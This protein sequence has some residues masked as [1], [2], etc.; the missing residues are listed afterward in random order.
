MRKEFLLL[1]KIIKEKTKN[2]KIYYLHNSGNYGDSLIRYGT[3][4]FFQDINLNFKQ[5][6]TF[7]LLRT[8][9]W[10]TLIKPNATLIFAGSGAWCKF[11][12]REAFI[13][14][15]SKRFKNIIILPSTFE[16]TPN[17]PNAIFF[18]R[19]NYESKENV[20]S[21]IFCHDMAFYIGSIES[22]KGNG[23]GY[24]FRKDIESLNK[25]NFIPQNIDISL[26]GNHL[27]PIFDF[28]NEISKY[29]IIY[30]D[31]LHV[32][33]GASL[34]KKE[35]HLFPNSYFKNKAIYLSSLKPFYENVYFHENF[36]L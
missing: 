28:I 30:T 23:K 15:I 18:R 25:V 21:S 22:E 20:P 2:G 9:W 3:M 36:D 33:I 19:D 5:I 31:R 7:N 35:V 10:P 12:N 11:Y 26:K 16:I 13:K 32:A 1:E 29:E 4:K 8:E 14:K 27:T 34:L 17:I 6:K 24:F